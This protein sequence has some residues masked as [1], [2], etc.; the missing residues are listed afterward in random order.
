[1][2]DTS[3]PDVQ[4]LVEAPH[5]IPSVSVQLPFEPKMAAKHELQQQL[6]SVY[7]SVKQQLSD[8]YPAEQVEPVL[9]KLSRIIAGLDYT[10]HKKS[11]CIFVSAISE[12]VLYLSVPVQE[13]VIIDESF[14]V[15]NVVYNKKMQKRFLLLLLGGRNTR[16]Y[17]GEDDTLE[18]VICDLPADITEVMNDLPEKVSNFS[19]PAA[20]KE[21]LL[22]KFLRQVDNCLTL[23]L[24]EYRLPLFVAGTDRVLGHFKAISRH[25]RNVVAFIPYNLADRGEPD[26]M[27]V[28]RPFI[29]DWEKLRQQDILLRLDKAGAAG[30]LVAGVTEIWKAASRGSNR[31]LVVEKN[32]MFPADQVS[33]DVIVPHEGGSGIY[34]K[35]AVDEIIEKVLRTGGD[36]EFVDD[37]QLNEYGHIALIRYYP[38]LG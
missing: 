9:K 28:V 8:S 29:S 34:I 7:Q 25:A 22:H 14:Q 10:T 16:L 33:K 18:R 13:K 31:L 19:D 21:N 3:H 35:D 37:G 36:V 1:M 20:R 24:D 38:V 23:I 32:F 15:R 12:K 5:Y 26:L 17:Q 6:K 2:K 30:R 11:I 27:P 4:Q